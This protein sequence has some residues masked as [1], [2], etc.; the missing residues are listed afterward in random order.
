MSEQRIRPWRTVLFVP[1]NKPRYLAS[2]IK[3][4]PDAVQLDLEDSVTPENKEQARALIEKA[5]AELRE[6]NI[7][8]IVR[9]N[10]EAKHLS[11]D[12]AAC[13]GE[14]INAIT[15]PKLETIAQISSI[16]QR[17]SNLEESRDLK[18][19]TIKLLGLIE[20]LTGLRNRENWLNAPKR[21]SGL[22][23]G[24]EDLCQQ[25]GCKPSNNNLIEPCRRVLYAAR[26]AGLYAWGMPLSIGEFT[27]LDGLKS[28]MQSSKEMG[29][30]GVWCIHPRQVEIA[31]AV[32]KLS[33]NELSQARKIV[34]AF[35]LASATGSGAV[36]VDGAMVDL[37]VYQRA[38]D[39][40]RQ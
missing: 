3:L 35:E 14:N 33:E 18:Q 8:S 29:F 31:N 20:T 24:S 9:I 17:I 30:D 28:A 22:A 6:N 36:N 23:L 2:A 40:L 15:I 34:A 13:V 26:E 39:L 1:A 4:K 37:P 11:Q 12:L 5:C 10:H 19:G 21:L 27:D 38:L 25:I 16:D 7:A 32:F